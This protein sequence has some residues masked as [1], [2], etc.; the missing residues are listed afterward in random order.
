MTHLCA[1]FVVGVW[2]LRKRDNHT[3]NFG[4]TFVLYLQTHFIDKY[5][6][7]GFCELAISSLSLLAKDTK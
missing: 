5:K 1:G 6:F 4:Y 7:E 3:K 2:L